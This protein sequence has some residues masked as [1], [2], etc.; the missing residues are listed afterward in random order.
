MPDIGGT[1]P[2]DLVA[3]ARAELGFS[4]LLDQP[5]RVAP[6]PC[7]GGSSGYPVVCR[8]IHLEK[9][10][11]GEEIQVSLSSI[12]RW[13]VHPG[14][15]HQTGNRPRTTVVG[16][17]LLNLVTHITT[18]PDATL[19]EMAAF[20]Y[21]EGGSLHRRPTHSP[22]LTLTMTTR[23]GYR[24]AMICT[25]LYDPPFTSQ[26]YLAMAQVDCSH[27]QFQRYMPDPVQRS[28]HIVTSRH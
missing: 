26:V 20:V 14:P 4:R 13:D 6:P 27:C 3:R 2:A 21:N 25:N 5:R 9:F 7:F 22:I 16:V 23:Q 11:A 15:Y 10:H 18:W 1:D 17:D 28:Y 8:A 19:D 24:I 12:Y